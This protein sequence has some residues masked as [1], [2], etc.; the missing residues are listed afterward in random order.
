ARDATARAPGAHDLPA[1][2]RHRA[3]RHLEADQELA[4]AAL[5]RVLERPLAD[6]VLLVEL[7]DP[8]HVRVED[9]RLRVGVLADDNVLLLET[10]DPL[11]LEPER[12]DAEVGAALEQRVPEVL[13]VQAREVELVAELADEADPEHQARHARHMRLVRVE[14]L[15][16]LV[17]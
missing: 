2:R 17:R 13:A 3:V 8:R 12:L 4:R 15:E 11:R 7:R 9:V 6:E 10:E 16:A 5:L 14:V 1:L